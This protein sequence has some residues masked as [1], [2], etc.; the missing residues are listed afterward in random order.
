VLNVYLILLQQ[1]GENKKLLSYEKSEGVYRRHTLSQFET[2]RLLFFVN[3][4]FN[5]LKDYSSHA[6]EDGLPE[7]R[8]MTGNVEVEFLKRDITN[9]PLGPAHWAFLLKGTTFFCTIAYGDEG[10]IIKYH[11]RERGIEQACAGIMGR[12]D[13]VYY[14]DSCHTNMNFAQILEQVDGMKTTWDAKN[15]HSLL[16][17]CQN[18][19]Q[20]LGCMMFDEFNYTDFLRGLNLSILGAV[21]A[22]NFR[23]QVRNLS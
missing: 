15:Y 12:M 19:V 5:Y 3:R 22:D 21:M 9:N 4:N 17:N 7:W 1:G 11:R 16:R 8:E 18:F 23:F 10:I 20:T 2:I 14:N 13:W 6:I